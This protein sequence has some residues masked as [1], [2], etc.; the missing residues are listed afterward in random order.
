MIRCTSKAIIRHQGKILLNQCAIDG[1]IYYDLPGGGQEQYE[2]MEAALEREIL[3][4]CG[5]HIRVTGLAAVG[6]QIALSSKIRKEFPAYAHRLFHLFS[7]EL[8]SER[9]EP[10]TN[11]D[12]WQQQCIWISPE[13][14]KNLEIL[15]A[16]FSPHISEIIDPPHTVYCGVRY[17][18]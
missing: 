6:E 5:Y 17:I 18:P 8:V 11:E 13:E 12:V 16:V 2:T 4:E 10:H 14:L 3:E 9:E 7:A 15:P 1:K